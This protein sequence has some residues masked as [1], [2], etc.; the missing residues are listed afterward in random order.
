M[1]YVDILTL[2]VKVREVGKH[3]NL[4]VDLEG[5]QHGATHHPTLAHPVQGLQVQW[6]SLLIGT[7]RMVGRATASAIAS[8]SM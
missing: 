7:K 3:A 6:S 2:A 1:V 5:R 4:F 8:A